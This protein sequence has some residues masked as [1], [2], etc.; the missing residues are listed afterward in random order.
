MKEILINLLFISIAV[1]FLLKNVNVKRYES[2]LNLKYLPDESK[3]YQDMFD[4]FEYY[5]VKNDTKKQ[6]EY[7]FKI[8]K[9]NLFRANLTKDK[10]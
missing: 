6:E 4:K 3:M 9:L 8:Y 5:S 10:N 7:L 1:Y 2:K